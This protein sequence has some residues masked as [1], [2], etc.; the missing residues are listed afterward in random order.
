MQFQPA[1]PTPG[2]GLLVEM[3]LK[4]EGEMSRKVDQIDKRTADRIAAAL[5][6]MDHP[7][8]SSVRLPW[9]FSA[10]T[11]LAWFIMRSAKWL[12]TGIAPWLS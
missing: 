3:T 10:R 2:E 5:D 4:V 7:T 11:R 12:A 1:I 9:L 8:R 6:Q